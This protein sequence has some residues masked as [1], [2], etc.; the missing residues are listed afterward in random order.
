MFQKLAQKF[1]TDGLTGSY[2]DATLAVEL[3]QMNFDQTTA[4]WAASQC[5]TVEQ[6]IAMLEQECELCTEKYPMNLMVSMLECT[7]KCCRECAKNYFTIQVSGRFP[8][9]RLNS[10]RLPLIIPFKDHR[11]KHHRLQLPFLQAARTA[12]RRYAG[13]GSIGV[14]LKLG[15]FAQEHL[16]GVGS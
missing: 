12:R 4:L 16:G 5:S 2:L 11:S 3:M 7:H 8:S 15:Y 9:L 6:A 13:R 10:L 14:F 1:V